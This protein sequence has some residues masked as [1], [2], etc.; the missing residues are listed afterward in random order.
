MH[1]FALKIAIVTPRLE[2][3]NFGTII[4]LPTDPE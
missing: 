3:G 2:P 4:T 1:E